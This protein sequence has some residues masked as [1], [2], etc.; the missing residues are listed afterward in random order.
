MSK[1]LALAILPLLALAACKGPGNEGDAQTPAFGPAPPV[2]EQAKVGL[3]EWDF[4]AAPVEG[5]SLEIEPD[6]VDFCAGSQAVTVRWDLGPGLATP[7]VWVQGGTAAPKLFAA[8][9]GARGE[10]A[11][12]P[13]VNESTIFFLVDGGNGRVLREVRPT[14]ARCN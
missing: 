3:P 8:P 14:P 6:P 12:G 5:F 1:K 13:W 7:Q 11:S 9:N 2:T 4:S 10:A